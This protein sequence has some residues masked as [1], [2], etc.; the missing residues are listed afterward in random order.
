MI[1]PRLPRPELLIFDADGTLIDVTRSYRETAPTAAGI[2]LR[3]LGLTPP[4]LTGDLYDTFK[5][6]TGFNDDWDLT[7]GLLHVLVSGLPPALPLPDHAWPGQDA[8]IAALRAAAAPLAGAMPPLPAWEPLIRDV[9][10]AGGGLA[11]LLRILPGHNAHLVWRTGD[12][13]TTDLVQRIFSEVYLG[14]DLFAAGYG[15][16]ARFWNGP[17]LIETE[18]PLIGQE[19]LAALRRVARLGIATG[20]T[21]F[22]MSHPLQRFDLAPFFGAIATMTDALEAQAPGGES[23]LKPHPYLLCRAADRLDPTG[24]L[25][26]A[27]VGDAPDDIMAARRAAASGGRRWLAIGI[28]AGPAQAEHYRQLGADL[29]IAH[30][31]ALLEVMRRM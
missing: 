16:P 29:I 27:Y 20:R 12:A 28:A 6:M 15:Y 30:P 25:P 7:A 11:G 9:R 21:R 3:L 2:Y 31:D 8:L 13:A 10:A 5:Q 24:R 19:T 26:A 18:E 14:A 4:P 23:L 22:E 17:G 1:Q